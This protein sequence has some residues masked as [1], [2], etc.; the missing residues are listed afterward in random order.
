MA[1]LDGKKMTLCIVG[2]GGAGGAIAPFFLENIDL[3][4]SMLS[5][6]TAAM[7]TSPGKLEGIWLESD[8]IEAKEKQNFFKECDYPIYYIPH[9][10]IQDN[11]DLHV[12]VSKKYGYDLKSQGYVRDAQYLKAIFEIFDTD[13]K[14]QLILGNGNGTSKQIQNPISDSA[15]ASIRPYTILGEGICDGILFIV[16]FGGGTGTGFINPIVN[17]IRS[18][19]KADFP[20]FILGILTEPGDK[21]IGD[22]FSS[23]GQRYLAAISALYDLA[24]KSGGANGIIL[25]DNQIL[26][27]RGGADRKSQNRFIYKAMRPMVLDRDYPG[28]KMAVRAI[29]KEFAKGFPLPPIFVPFYWS[30]PRIDNPEYQLVTDALKKGGL[31]DCSP[32][33]A[34]EKAMVFCRGYLSEEKIIEAISSQTK[35]K[36]KDIKVSR[37]MSVGEDEILILLR[38]PYGGDPGAFEKEGTLEC[39]ICSLIDSAIAYMDEKADELFYEDKQ[40]IEAQKAGKKT[41]A[42]LTDISRSALEKFFFGNKGYTK[43]NIGKTDGF[44]FELLEARRRLVAGEKPFFNK[45]LRIFYKGSK[46]DPIENEGKAE[47]YC[48]DK[49]T[50]DEIINKLVDEKKVVE[51]IGNLVDAKIAERIGKVS[52]SGGMKNEN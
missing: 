47:V 12:E 2:I 32:E 22:Q 49:K 46:N 14:I 37:K 16:S 11:S 21:T 20:V 48:F 33:N 30:Q 10:A 15:W 18:G 26:K 35:I 36:P 27:R 25:M 40:S 43:G 29:G 7:H 50:I 8:K 24:T 5:W 6:I 28:Q 51:T 4:S 44:A 17:N 34:D 3:N 39:K 31:F 19:G 41:P 13:D 42:K 23:E 52:Q 9:D 38:N 45:E 1:N